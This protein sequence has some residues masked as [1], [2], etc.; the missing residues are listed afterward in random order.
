M[1][2]GLYIS[3][4]GA[5]AQS[6][7]MD[8]I[9]NNLA[10]VDTVG[11][12]RE[13]AILRARSTEAVDQGLSLPGSGTIDDVGG[14]IAM[15]QTVTDHATGPPKKTDAKTDVAIPQ[16]GVFFAVQKGEET[17][18]TRAGNFA[19]TPDRRLTT[20]QGYNVLDSAGNPIFIR[21]DPAWHIDGT[22]I[23][24]QLGATQSL[25]LVQ[26]E[27]LG[28]LVKA[29]ENLFRPLA[30]TTDVP[31]NERQVKSGYLEMSTVRPTS[32]MTDLIHA[33]RAMEANINMMKTQNEM[34]AGLINRILK[35]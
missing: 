9:A 12:K 18:L 4:E 24:Q 21:D 7:R 22:G 32:E 16:P 5:H 6:Q 17:L 25:A 23:V 34:L 13:L 3:A 8:V 30:E 29:G 14:G 2:Y 31:L 19:I 11:F 27:S 20:Q 33:S 26:P 1:P 28:D 10:N 35:A 15:W